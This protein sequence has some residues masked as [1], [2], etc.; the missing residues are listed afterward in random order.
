MSGRYTTAWQD[1]LTF[2]RCQLLK[3]GALCYEQGQNENN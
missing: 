2:Q 1:E 3:H